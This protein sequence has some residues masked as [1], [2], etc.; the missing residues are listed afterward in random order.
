MKSI[1]NAYNIKG[2]D[3]YKLI[4]CF[5]KKTGDSWPEIYDTVKKCTVFNNENGAIDVKKLIPLAYALNADDLIYLEFLK[6]YCGEIPEA[7]LKN[8]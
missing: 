6:E 4:I 1:V 7:I 8:H 2:I 3:R 5:C